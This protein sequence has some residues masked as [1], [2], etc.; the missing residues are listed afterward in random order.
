MIFYFFKPLNIDEQ[1]FIDV[2]LF[3]IKSF[4]LY[5]LTRDGLKT[6]MGGEKALK[7]TDRY[8]VKKINFRDHTQQYISTMRANEGLYKN[9]IVYL[10]GNVSFKREDGLSFKSQHVIYNKNTSVVSTNDKYT[11]YLGKNKMQ[12]TSIEYNTLLNT[13]KSKNIE[14][15]YNLEE[16]Q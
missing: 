11:A 1:E 7:Y 5:E 10:D 6:F 14:V 4:S 2:P 9:N 15:N 12:G 13:M 16:R 8:V 3:E